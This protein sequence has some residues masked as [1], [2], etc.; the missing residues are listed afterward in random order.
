MRIM[1]SLNAKITEIEVFLGNKLMKKHLCKCKKMHPK[2]FRV[3]S[4]EVCRIA[5]NEF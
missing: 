4:L 1:V 2:T 3:S 5:M